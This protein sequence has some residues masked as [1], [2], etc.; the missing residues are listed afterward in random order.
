MKKSV[1]IILWIIGILV[2]LLVI[3]I[4]IGLFAPQTHHSSETVRLSASLEK[5][6][7]VL[8][9][10]EALPERRPEIKK[11]EEELSRK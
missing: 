10:I 8:T 2:G 7:Q 11:I 1:K 3:F 9:D 6:W 4:L 5:V